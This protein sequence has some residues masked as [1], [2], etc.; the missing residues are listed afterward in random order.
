MRPRRRRLKNDSAQSQG[1]KVAHAAQAR[2]PGS[3][4]VCGLGETHREREGARMPNQ[5]NNVKPNNSVY[6]LQTLILTQLDI[7]CGGCSNMMRLQN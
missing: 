3:P 6:N 7:Y 2:F 1:R 4:V 5:T